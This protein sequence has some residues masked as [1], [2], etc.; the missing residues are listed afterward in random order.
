LGDGDVDV[1]GLL[2]RLRSDRYG[3]WYV[4]EQ[5]VAL[6]GEPGDGEGPLLDAARSVSCFNRMA[7]AVANG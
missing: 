6:A 7:A 3:G 5:D 2:Q 1:A 4:L